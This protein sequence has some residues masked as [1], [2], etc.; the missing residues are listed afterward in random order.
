MGKIICG[1]SCIGKSSIEKFDK[2]FTYFDLDS[3]YF[4]KNEGWEEVY[5]E[6]AKALALVYDYVFLTTYYSVMEKLNA[7]NIEW[8]LIYPQKTLKEEYRA[9]AIKR[10]SPQD[11][12]QGFFERWDEHIKD[13]E[14][15]KNAN[16]IELKAGQYL[17]N[18]INQ[19]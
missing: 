15:I 3:T 16:K 12:V 17:S 1:F 18:V 4:K 6:C 14:K 2:K 19:I 10:L 9:R 5:I 11:F 8:T 7:K 13:C